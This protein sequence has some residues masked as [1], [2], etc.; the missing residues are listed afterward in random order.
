MFDLIVSG[1]MVYSTEPFIVTVL[2]MDIGGLGGG[3]GG[4]ER[5]DFIEHVESQCK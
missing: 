3:G 1:V 4:W 2:M 5:L